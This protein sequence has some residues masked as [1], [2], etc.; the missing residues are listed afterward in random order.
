MYVIIVGAGTVGA[1]LVELGFGQGH[2]VAVIEPDKERA[3]AVAKSCDAL[4]LHASIVD[5]GILEKVDAARADALVATTSDDAQNLMAIVLAR[6]AEI[7]SVVSVVNESSHRAL[8]ERMGAHVLVEP[9]EIIAKHLLH[10][11]QRRV[12]SDE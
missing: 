5:A 8:F 11:A 1:R 3:D 9:E 7:G 10:I 4:V 6:E 2:E 12:E